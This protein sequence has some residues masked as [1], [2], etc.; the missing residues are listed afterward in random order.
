MERAQKPAISVIV[1][2]YNGG[3][4]LAQCLEGIRQSSYQYYELIVVDNGSTDDS[5]AIAQAY[6]AVVAH[7]PGPSGPGAARNVGV[8]LAKGRI[9]LFVDADVVVHDDVLDRVAD[10]FGADP[11]LAAVFGSYDDRPAAQ[12]F[13]SQYKNLLHH[14]VHQQAKSQATTFWAG[15]GAIRKDVFVKAGG[16]DQ[17]K[18]PT[19]SI[20]DIELGGRLHRQGYRI[21]LDKAIHATHLKEWRLV[22][23]LRAEIC[24]RAIPW[25]RLIL[26]RQG[27]VNDL[28]LKMSQRASA[29]VAG[30]FLAVLPGTLVVPSLAYGCLF[31]LCLFVLLNRDLFAFFLRRRGVVFSA[32]TIPMHGFYF[33]Y[34][35][36][37]FVLMW[38]AHLCWGPRGAVAPGRK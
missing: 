34:S 27:L 16:F 4:C 17:E 22:S 28:N 14:F 2:V 37:T 30:L 7:C 11:D 10:R 35:G 25:S 3:W 8:H 12:N 36:V 15:C 5:V 18:Y 32:M 1:P 38:L 26:E 6:G 24:Y 23:L 9:L 20:E 19:P 13:L 29:G 21:C 31:L 33:V